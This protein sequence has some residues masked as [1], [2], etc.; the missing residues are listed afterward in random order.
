MIYPY[1]KENIKKYIASL[2][3][4]ISTFICKHKKLYNLAKNLGIW[5]EC[6]PF[7]KPIRNPKYTKEFILTEA[8]KYNSRYQLQLQAN[9][10]YNTAVRYDI[11]DEACSHMLPVRF[12]IP[13]MICKDI[14]DNLLRLNGIYNDCNIIYP[15]ELD[16]YYPSINLGIEY[17]GNIHHDRN[18]PKYEENIFRDDT[19]NN[20]CKER[21]IH[22]LR[23]KQIRNNN[24]NYK[25]IE[26]DIK[27]QIVE[28]L[29]EINTLISHVITPN[30]VTSFIV[31]IN[32]FYDIYNLESIRKMSLSY[33]N[34]SQ[35]MKNHK[36][37]YNMLLKI[38]RL[39]ILDHLRGKKDHFIW[40]S[41]TDEEIIEY[42]L[43]NYKSYN[44]A[45]NTRKINAI[46]FRRKISK[47]LRYA[48]DTR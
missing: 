9:H 33:H 2:N 6:K 35:F 16:I 13:Q 1:E 23:I 26:E 31:D 5:E 19:K 24:N 39:D 44:Q 40:A 12:S 30:V 29:D 18:N 3:I 27:N 17:D 20:I 38:K 15:M 45:F 21:N 10:I 34:V 42:I 11:L 37:L 41:K 28:N 25:N 48:F 43:Y 22:L 14:L 46:I 4:S 32:K 7:L 47:Q 36:G 8:K